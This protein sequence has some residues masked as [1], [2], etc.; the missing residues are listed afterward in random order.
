[1]PKPL[2]DIH[3]EL[4]IAVGIEIGSGQVTSGIGLP[5]HRLPRTRFQIGVAIIGQDPH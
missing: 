4:T 3:V 5:P 2:S 1:M